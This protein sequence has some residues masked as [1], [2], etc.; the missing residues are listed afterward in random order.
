MNPLIDNFREILKP[1]SGCGNSIWNSIQIK[2]DTMQY[3]VTVIVEA[4]T[5]K[6]AVS[7]VPDEL[8]EVASVNP[9][10]TVQRPHGI[11]LPSIPTN[12]KTGQPV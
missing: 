8:G 1:C 12:M 3:A 6:A 10:P 11:P 9:R 4:D 5:L 7:K 2:E